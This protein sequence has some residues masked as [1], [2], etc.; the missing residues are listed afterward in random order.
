M[1][2]KVFFFKSKGCPQ[3]QATA[4]AFNQVAETLKD[5]IQVNAI[6]IMEDMQTAIDNG[7]MSV[8]T[9]I[10]FRDNIELKRL[11]GIVS[12]DKLEKTIREFLEEPTAGR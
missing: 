10:I 4:P 1:G 12:K 11:N 5:K 8:P 9:I 2:I 7:V 3:C 6:D